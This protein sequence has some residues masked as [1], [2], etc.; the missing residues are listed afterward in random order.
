MSKC[1]DCGICER[2]CQ[3]HDGYERYDNFSEPIVYGCRH[4]DEEELNRSQSGAASWAIIQAFLTEPGVVYGVGFD[5]PT[6]I[7]HKRATTLQECQEFRGSKYVQSDLREIFPEVKKDLKDGNRV[8]FFGTG[9][10][11][12][13]LKSY[14]PTKLY[15]NLITVDLV[16]HA[17]GSPK[18]WQQYIEYLEKKKKLRINRANFRDKKYGWRTCVET[19]QYNDGTVYNNHIFKFF[20]FE[21]LIVRDSCSNCKYT[22]MNRVGDITIADFIGWEKH[23]DIWNDTK[24]ISLLMVNSPKGEIIKTKVENFMD[25]V[26]SDS[27]KCQQPQLREPIKLNPEYIN[28]RNYF[29]KKGFKGIAMRY[30]F[31]PGVKYYMNKFNSFKNRIYSIMPKIYHKIK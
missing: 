18:F 24:G 25:F 15:T 19:F 16:C 2:V 22:N 28:V 14:I 27:I 17:S 29:N 11:V 1:T 8:L 6:H 5:T 7:I 4:K 26:H 3:F 9:C 23:Y 31:V 13:G 21:H 10:Q 20:Y 12:S 30:G